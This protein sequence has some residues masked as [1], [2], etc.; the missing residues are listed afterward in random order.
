MA[1]HYVA[2][3]GGAL[4]ACR[5]CLAPGG[6]LVF[7]VVHPVITSHD[8]RESS[9]EPR[10][11]WVVDD[12]FVSGPRNQQWLGTRT[13]WQHR[14]IEDYVTELLVPA[15]LS[16]TCASAHRVASVLTTT[17]SLSGGCAFRS[18][19]SCLVLAPASASPP[20]R[21]HR[22]RGSIY[23]RS[24]SS[25]ATSSTVIPSSCA[26]VGASSMSCKRVDDRPAQSE[27]GSYK[28]KLRASQI[29]QRQFSL[30]EIDFDELAVGEKRG[31]ETGPLE[32][33]SGEH[34]ILEGHLLDGAV[35]E[36]GVVELATLEA[37][38]LDPR[39]GKIEAGQSSI[40]EPGTPKLRASPIAVGC[41]NT[42]SY[43]IDELNCSQLGLSEI[44]VLQVHP[45]KAPRARIR[46]GERHRA[47]PNI[48]Q[49]KLRLEPIELD[50]RELIGEQVGSLRSPD[51]AMTG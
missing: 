10:Q 22:L 25:A 49:L 2:D 21:T 7:T 31:I 43:D 5:A 14:T 1:L 34:A 48:L 51:R 38:L 46:L 47:D 13:V 20:A 50:A 24:V 39:L 23:P 27:H 3:L 42:L 37:H 11:N 16:P 40:A 45:L 12:Y 29:D 18:C 35:T 19:S 28:R 26:R 32:V 15:S 41:I 44:N 4:R 30:G 33:R 36:V 17:P 8:A 6:R 9:A